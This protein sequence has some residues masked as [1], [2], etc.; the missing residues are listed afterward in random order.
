MTTHL[1]LT[2]V[3]E[4]IER[5]RQLLWPPKKGIWIRIALIA[6]FLGGGLISPPN[7]DNLSLSSDGVLT[8]SPDRLGDQVD[9]M[10]TVASGIVVAGLLYVIL[11]AIFQF[12]FVDC[13][14]SGSVTLADPFRLRWRKGMHLVGF[15]LFLLLIILICMVVLT[16]FF[17]V[18]V[19]TSGTPELVSLLIAVVQMLILL[20]LILIPVWIVAILTSDFV[21]PVMIIDDAGIIA[22]WCRVITLFS[23]RWIEAGIYTGLKIMLI[24]ISGMIIGV[25]AFLIS[26]PFSI[27]IFSGSIGSEVSGS[28]ST[29]FFGLLVGTIL[30]FLVSLFLLVPVLTFFRYYSLA[31]LRTL[32]SRYDLL[33]QQ[34]E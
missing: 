15:Y 27:G 4:S 13:L 16:L 31:V 6:L 11:S 23:G 19:L 8:M 30:I 34:Q 7:L 1:A 14:S 25:A 2:T 3:D 18:P 10:L 33:S 9:L 5:T 22:G 28:G 17:L 26:L 32:D 21:V 24:V 20:F 29:A 12:V